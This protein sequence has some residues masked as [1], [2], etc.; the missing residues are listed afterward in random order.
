MEEEPVVAAPAVDEPR[1]DA[2]VHAEQPAI[3]A[4]AAFTWGNRQR[5]TE[6]RDRDSDDDRLP[7]ETWVER[8]YRGPRERDV[9]GGIAEPMDPDAGLP[10]AMSEERE[11]ELS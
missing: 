9:A 7:G 6:E 11:W 4:P 8:A 3:V 1:H 2:I 5:A 10:E